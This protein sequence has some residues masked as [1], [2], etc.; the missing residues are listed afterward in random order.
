MINFKVSNTTQLNE[1][2]HLFG[3]SVFSIST[4]QV[5]KQM[6]RRYVNPV[7]KTPN[8]KLIAHSSNAYRIE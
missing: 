3:V 4:V 8:I 6:T 2:G 7:N 5:L 1:A